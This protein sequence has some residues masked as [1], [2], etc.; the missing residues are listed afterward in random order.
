MPT[1]AQHARIN[2]SACNT[3]HIPIGT[4]IELEGRHANGPVAIVAATGR[5]AHL[6]VHQGQTGQQTQAADRL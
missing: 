3:W 1:S 2:S 5:T 6:G 4:G